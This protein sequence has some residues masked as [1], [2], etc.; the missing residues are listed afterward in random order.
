VVSLVIG[1]R[2]V[3]AE[4]VAAAGDTLQFTLA[5][6]RPMQAAPVRLRVDGAESSFVRFD[7]TTKGFAFD[8][9]Q[10]VTIQ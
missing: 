6:A 3:R 7:D 4:P 5:D 9:A 8:D 1:D 10:R 2:E